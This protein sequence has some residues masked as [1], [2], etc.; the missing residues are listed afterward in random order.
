MATVRDILAGKSADLLTVGPGATVLEAALLMNE[1]RVG[2]LLVLDGGGLCGI[3]TERDILRRVVAERRDP[4]TTPIRDVMTADV[5]CCRP[6]TN[7]EEARVVMMERRIRH[8]PVLDDGGLL[9]GM[10]SIGDL[11]AHEAHSKDQTIHLLHEYIYGHAQAVGA[12]RA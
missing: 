12:G 9:C 6:H 4:C 11:N 1:R 5:M 7:I 10:V 8:L 3:F 2:S